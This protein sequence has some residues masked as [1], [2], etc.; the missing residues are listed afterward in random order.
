MRTIVVGTRKSL[1]AVTQTNQV[2]DHLREL[3]REA[4][5][6]PRV[7]LEAKR[8]QAVAVMVAAGAGIAVLPKSLARVVGNAAEVIPLRNAAP[9]AH[10]F[11]R[12]AGEP[13]QGMRWFLESLDAPAGG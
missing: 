2:I 5:F 10:V 13:T 12:V 8:A 6:R 3:C 11:A 4:G 1:L 9:L 7:V